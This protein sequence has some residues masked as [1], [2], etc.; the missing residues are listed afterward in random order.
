MIAAILWLG[1]YP[2]PVFKTITPALHHLDQTV[3]RMQIAARA[4]AKAIVLSETAKRPPAQ[5]VRPK[6]DNP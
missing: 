2:Q 6:G 4:P 1:L 3:T 5:S